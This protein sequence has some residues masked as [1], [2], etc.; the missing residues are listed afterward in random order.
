MRRCVL[1]VFVTVSG[2][3]AAWPAVSPGKYQL[4][5]QLT[6]V[7]WQ[8]EKKL[9]GSWREFPVA[10]YPEFNNETIW[11]WSRH[12]KPKTS[13]AWVSFLSS[14]SFFFL[15]EQF[16]FQQP[17]D[18]LIYSVCALW[19]PRVCHKRKMRM[20]GVGPFQMAILSACSARLS[21]MVSTPDNASGS[22]VNLPKGIN[23]EPLKKK[24]EKKRQKEKVCHQ[25]VEKLTRKWD[26]CSAKKG[27]L[28]WQG[29][30]QGSDYSVA[31]IKRSTFP[32]SLHIII[33]AAA[34]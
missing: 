17:V 13:L 25:C 24:K 19:L 33:L 28:I 12:R 15:K 7:G 27:V 8:H 3:R 2:H 1:P 9:Q 26:C 23:R 5:C 16:A 18:V 30:I 29:D 21:V 14:S 11:H 31:V 20:N 22:R 34:T 10:S 4:S 32:S 6:V